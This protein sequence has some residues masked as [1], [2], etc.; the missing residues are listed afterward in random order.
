MCRAYNGLA[1]GGVDI[2]VFND[3]FLVYKMKIS[4]LLCGNVVIGS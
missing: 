4:K 1:G 2:N 3:R